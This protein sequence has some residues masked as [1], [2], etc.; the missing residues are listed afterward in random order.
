MYSL[1]ILIDMILFFG[2]ISKG[3]IAKSGIFLEGVH[4]LFVADLAL[5]LFPLESALPP[6][7]AHECAIT[8]R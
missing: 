2:W 6:S 7:M 4:Q 5:E 1:D 3:K 8:L